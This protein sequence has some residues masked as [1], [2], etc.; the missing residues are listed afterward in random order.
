MRRTVLAAAIATTA[1]VALTACGGDSDDSSDDTPPAKSPAA[2]NRGPATDDTAT[3]ATSDTAALEKSVRDY[4]RALFSGDGPTGYDLLSARCKKLTDP[5]N[6]QGLADDAHHQYGNLEIKE[7]N[8]D[9]ISGDLARVSYSVGVPALER[10]AQ[11]WVREDGT[12]RWDACQ[13]A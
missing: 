9:T 1:L 8:I 6:F 13:S 5:D 11:P 3:D 7:I 2:S 10:E 4:T 12:W